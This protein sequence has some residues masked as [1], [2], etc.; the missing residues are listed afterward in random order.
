MD[1]PDAPLAA[2][3]RALLQQESDHG[4][5]CRSCRPGSQG[6]EARGQRQPVR[7]HA[8]DRVPPDRRRARRVARL[9]RGGGGTDVLGGVR[10]A[11]APG[12]GRDRPRRN[13]PAAQGGGKPA[14]PRAPGEADRRT[15][16]R[17]AGRRIARGRHSR[18]PLCGHAAGRDRR[19]RRRSTPPHSRGL[20]RP[21]PAG[22]QGAGARAI[23][24]APD[25]SGG[26][27]RRHSVD[28]S[29]RYR[30]AAE[31]VRSDQAGAGCAR[32]VFRRGERQVERDRPA[33]RHRSRWH[34]GP[35]PLSPGSKGTPG[36]SVLIRCI[37]NAAAR[38][39][40][41]CPPT[42]TAR[43]GLSR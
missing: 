22:L 33:V 10:L 18:H 15:Q 16:S 4:S 17:H 26:G 40:R 20:H 41:T 1:A 30:H 3:I 2:A 34:Y 6:A 21:D 7:R 31:G 24:H 36:K 5:R 32:D 29:A 12:R 42:R 14:A 11:D 39:K 37:W 25:R 38:E 23:Q 35:H 28:A 19:A 43:S 27:A 13:R 9:E 8:G